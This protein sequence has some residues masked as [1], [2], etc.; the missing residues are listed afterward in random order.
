MS[1][2]VLAVDEI[3]GFWPDAGN[4]QCPDRFR[5]LVLTEVRHGNQPRLTTLFSPS[6]PALSANRNL[7]A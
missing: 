2:I 5:V 7:V 6:L 3:T 1:E 4:S